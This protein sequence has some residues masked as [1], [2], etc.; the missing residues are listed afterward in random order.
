MADATIVQ[1]LMDR[2]SLSKV[3]HEDEVMKLETLKQAHVYCVIHN[4]SA[5][6][7][8]PLLERFIRTKFGYTK[9]KT[10]DCIGDCAKDGKNSE[11]KVSLGGSTHSKFNFVQIRPLH[12]CEYILTAYHLSHENVKEEGSMHVFRVSSDEMKRLIVDFGGYAHG[13]VKEHGPITME[14]FDEKKVREYAIRPTVGDECWKA[15]L[16]FSIPESSL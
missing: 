16:P 2:L 6:R 1:Q 9:N 15:L 8:G 4:L 11:I 12:K 14:S 13:T 10:E 7:Y 5:Q 3:N